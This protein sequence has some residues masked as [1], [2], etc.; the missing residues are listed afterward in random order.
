[1]VLLIIVYKIVE[2]CDELELK[3]EEPKYTEFFEFFTHKSGLFI[4]QYTVGDEIRKGN[5]LG[6]LIDLT[7]MEESVI[8]YN[9]GLGWIICTGE[10]QYV[11]P[12]QS[13]YFIQPID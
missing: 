5:I 1:M 9:R 8:L 6:K 2:Y 7:T 3:K 4:P 10:T 11:S 13:I 12:S